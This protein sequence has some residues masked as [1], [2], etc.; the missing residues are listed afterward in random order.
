MWEQKAL[1]TGTST[2]LDDRVFAMCEF[3]AQP[4]QQTMRM[5]YPDMYRMDTLSDQVNTL[6]L[7]PH[8]LI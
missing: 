8:P 6:A 1:R 2:R 7:I 5:V 3:K 4:L